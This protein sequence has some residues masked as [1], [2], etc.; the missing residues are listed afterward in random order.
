[1]PGFPFVFGFADYGTKTVGIVK[2]VQP[3]GDFNAGLSSYSTVVHD[4]PYSRQ[5]SGINDG[6][7]MIPGRS[8]L[9]NEI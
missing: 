7:V 8:R 3:T 1:M 9:F 4:E 5:I 6:L 2:T